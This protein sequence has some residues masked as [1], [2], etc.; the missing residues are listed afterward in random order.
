MNKAEPITKTSHDGNGD[1]TDPASL[2]RGPYI[3]PSCTGSG[4]IQVIP[5]VPQP[6][7]P[8]FAFPWRTSHAHSFKPI[9]DYT[10]GETK[11]K[12]VSSATA[13]EIISIVT[14]AK[15]VQE[16]YVA[17]VCHRCGTVIQRPTK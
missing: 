5:L 4:P 12:G 3:Q 11:V 6:C 15:P 2:W 9:Y 8:H 13:A 7:L 17:H 14:A 1:A 16:T 10:E